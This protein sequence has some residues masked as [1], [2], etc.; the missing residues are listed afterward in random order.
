MKFKK[1]VSAVS[2]LALSV[3]AFAGLMGTAEAAETQQTLT[4]HTAIVGA[5][6]TVAD[7]ESAVYLNSYSA[8]GGAF[9]LYFQLDD[10]F[11][12][13]K[14]LSAELSLYATSRAS[15]TNRSGSINFFG[16]T[17]KTT[18]SNVT[19]TTYHDGAVNVYQYGSTNT[20]RY[21]YSGTPFTTV[22]T[23][24]GDIDLNAYN[25]YDVTS[26]FTSLTDKNGGDEVYIGVSIDDWA[27]DT[28]FAGYGSDNPPILTIEYAESSIYTATFTETNGADITVTVNN[29]DVSDTGFS[30]VAGTYNFTATAPGY[31]TYN[32]EFTISN[33]D[34]PVSFTMTPIPSAPASMNSSAPKV[35]SAPLISGDSGYVSSNIGNPITLGNTD[36]GAIEF[37]I[38]TTA[39]SY[40]NFTLGNVNATG[41][42]IEFSSDS[43]TTTVQYSINSNEKENIA[44]YTTGQW[45]HVKIDF[46]TTANTEGNGSPRLDSCK[47]T[48]TPRTNGEAQSANPALRNLAANFSSG[49]RSY[50]FEQIKISGGANIANTEMYVL[51]LPTV[52][53]LANT[54]EAAAINYVGKATAVDGSAALTLDGTEEVYTMWIKTEHCNDEYPTITLKQGD[55][56]IDSNVNITKADVDTTEGSNTNG[57]FCVQILK[58][59]LEAGDYTAT[60]ASDGT[61]CDVNFTVAE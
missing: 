35:T 53:A 7:Y 54:V 36:T 34:L 11:D 17:N 22:S 29:N 4:G 13:S 47:V 46:K 39:G 16:L 41:P 38:Y 60:F 56:V 58:E 40:A 1:L 10:T 18:I 14:V 31:E 26:Y 6:K 19:P 50:A 37:D 15:N 49:N 25:S 12:A 61:S 27:F 32:G 44:T 51:S 24:V 9:E 2:A 45:A 23:T 33:Q 5:N 52:T 42:N 8:I 21:T 20:K 57:Y 59:G 30:G 55:N 43:D 28:T 3:T 48:I